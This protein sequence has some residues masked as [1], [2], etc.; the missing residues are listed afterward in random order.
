MGLCSLCA[1]SIA[2]G[3]GLLG[4]FCH[5]IGTDG[6]DAGRSAIFGCIIGVLVG[7]V[8]FVA[9]KSCFH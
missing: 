6:E 5:Y 8:T 3:A 7:I 1:F 4:G 2:G 9:T